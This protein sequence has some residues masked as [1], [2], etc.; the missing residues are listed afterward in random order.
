[1][2]LANYVVIKVCKPQLCTYRQ[3]IY[4][5]NY[6]EN[7]VELENTNEFHLLNMIIMTEFFFSFFFFF[8]A[9][10]IFSRKL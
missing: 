2:K 9:E 6:V 4:H 10:K 7:T 3:H 8:G 1:M 5:F